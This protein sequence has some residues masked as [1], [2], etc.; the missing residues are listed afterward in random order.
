MDADVS[1]M[2]VLSCQ[3]GI[4]VDWMFGV[5]GAPKMIADRDTGSINID[6][7]QEVIKEAELHES[8]NPGSLSLDRKAELMA[9]LYARR[10]VKGQ[11]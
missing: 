1:L 8:I 2:N 3:R 6:L 10:A 7:L 4:S 9:R 11:N 5:P